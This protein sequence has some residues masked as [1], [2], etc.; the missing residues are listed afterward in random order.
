MDLLLTDTIINMKKEE[1]INLVNNIIDNE[2][3]VFNFTSQIEISIGDVTIFLSESSSARS[4]RF[5][6]KSDRFLQSGDKFL[7]S[8]DSAIFI[9]KSEYTEL[10]NKII[11]KMTKSTSEII[12]MLN[13]YIREDKLKSLIDDVDTI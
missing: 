4:I 1:V 12:G 10:R 3:T 2:N 9:D 7:I 6:Y 8:G 11:K 13:S 5:N